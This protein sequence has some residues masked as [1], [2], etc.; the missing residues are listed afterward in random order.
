[1]AT[2][3]SERDKDDP[4][5]LAEQAREQIAKQAAD[6]RTEKVPIETEPPATYRP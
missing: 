6:L 2:E 4:T 5:L 1:M 3:K